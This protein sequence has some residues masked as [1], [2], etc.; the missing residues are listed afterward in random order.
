MAAAKFS[1]KAQGLI[2]PVYGALTS[3]WEGEI[4]EQG[5]KKGKEN[6]QC[7]RRG[8]LPKATHHALHCPCPQRQQAQGLLTGSRTALGN[9]QPNGGGRGITEEG[10]T[11]ALPWEDSRLMGKSRASDSGSRPSGCRVQPPRTESERSSQGS[12]PGGG[13][14]MP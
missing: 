14:T 2:I 1:L 5:S 3:A 12:L 6:L 8:S 7:L 11:Q 4:S 9:A 13:R 10:Q